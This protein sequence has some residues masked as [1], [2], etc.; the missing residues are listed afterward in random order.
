M[1]TYEVPITCRGGFPSWESCRDILYDMPADKRPEV[2]GPPGDP[3]VT[4][5]LPHNIISCKGT[6]S[7]ENLNSH[8]LIKAHPISRR[9]MFR[10]PIQYWQTG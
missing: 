4:E 10:P 8:I 7:P 3:T 1:G 6:S 2:F 9:E 5:P